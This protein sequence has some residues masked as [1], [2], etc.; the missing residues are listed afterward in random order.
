VGKGSVFYFEIPASDLIIDALPIQKNN[1]IQNTEKIHGS[2]F[3]KN[4]S[5]LIVEDTDHN[6]ILLR[7][8]V[9]HYGAISDRAINGEEGLMKFKQKKYDLILLDI[10]M[11]KMDGY[12]VIKVIRQTNQNV[13][14]FAVTANA[15]SNEKEKCL[16]LGFTDYMAKPINPDSLINMINNYLIAPAQKAQKKVKEES[17]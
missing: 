15:M 4:I 1:R 12:E 6:Y 8:I 3:L 11:P 14:V 2:D 17:I 10:N 7:E 16:S 5:I 9:S 13:P